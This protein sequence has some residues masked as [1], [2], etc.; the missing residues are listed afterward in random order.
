MKAVCLHGRSRF[1]EYGHKDYR[2]I[3]FVDRFVEMV[4]LAAVSEMIT[5]HVCALVFI[6]TIFRL[7]GLPRELLFYLE[8]RFT[9]E[10]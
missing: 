7:H 9:V 8:P 2:I 5:E 1:P 4:H 10:S 3:V 6:D